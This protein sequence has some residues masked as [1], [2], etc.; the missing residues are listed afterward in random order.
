[1]TA[2]TEPEEFVF[3]KRLALELGA[4]DAKIIPTDLIAVEDRVVLKCKMGCDKYGKTLMCPPHAPTPEEFRKIVS[5]Y[6]YAMFMKF[7][8]K[9]EANEEL[10]TQLGKSQNDPTIP[11]SMKEKVDKFW[12]DWKDDKSDM[13]S[14]VIKLEKE[15]MKK[16]YLLTIGLV[17]GACLICEKCNVAEGICIHPAMSRYSEEGVGVNVQKTAKNAGILMTFPFEKK[18]ESFAL[19]LID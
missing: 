18:P 10:M 19:L 14:Q 11:A 12:A 15:A 8:S 6:N 5:E 9:A 13:L 7:P 4:S 1:L 16:G 3:L 17:S 2:R